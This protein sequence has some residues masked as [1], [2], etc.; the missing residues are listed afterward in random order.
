MQISGTYKKY[1]TQIGTPTIKNNNIKWSG[2]KIDATKLLHRE[3]MRNNWCL[4]IS[5]QFSK[6]LSQFFTINLTYSS[7]SRRL[8]TQ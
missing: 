5:S 7:I 2:F 4:R 8:I 1:L 3:M 6:I